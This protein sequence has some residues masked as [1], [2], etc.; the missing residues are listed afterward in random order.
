[1]T[2]S[3]LFADAQVLMSD[4]IWH[5]TCSFDKI[6]LSRRLATA[7]AIVAQAKMRFLMLS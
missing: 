6:M 2:D 5:E 4:V 3:L 1:M 7:L